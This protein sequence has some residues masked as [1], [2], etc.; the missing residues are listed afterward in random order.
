MAESF[1]PAMGERWRFVGAACGMGD[2]GR[3]GMGGGGSRNGLTSES[4]RKRRY[5]ERMREQAE[6][7][8]TAEARGL[9]P[10]RVPGPVLGQ[11]NTGQPLLDGLRNIAENEQTPAHA[12]VTAFRAVLEAQGQLGRHAPPP[13][14]KAEMLP[15]QLLTR[16][17]LVAELA[18]LRALRTTT[19]ERTSPEDDA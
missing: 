4:L 9:G 15:P 7:Q 8:K 13:R 11:Q 16:A 3:D 6:A 12:R 5:R 19:A 1:R 17:G 2:R 18:R 14:D 10:D